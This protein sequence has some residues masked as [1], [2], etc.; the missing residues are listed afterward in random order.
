MSLHVSTHCCRRSWARAQGPQV[1][2]LRLR[3]SISP[4]LTCDR[5]ADGDE[6][7]W[8]Q[9]DV[10]RPALLGARPPFPSATRLLITLA[11]ARG[12]QGPR[13]DFG[14]VCLSRALGNKCHNC[15]SLQKVLLAGLLAAWKLP[16]FSPWEREKARLS[17]GTPGGALP[18]AVFQPASRPWGVYLAHVHI[19]VRVPLQPQAQPARCPAPL[20]SACIE[21]ALLAVPPKSAALHPD[22]RSGP[23]RS[24]TL[25][26]LGSS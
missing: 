16:Y 25:S 2:T 19:P 10:P 18:P 17:Y 21:P 14:E 11:L 7:I 22:R 26:P 1:A 8:R 15:L 12:S 20:D 24:Q 6:A 4:F 23:G 9:A 13:Q 3:F 5:F